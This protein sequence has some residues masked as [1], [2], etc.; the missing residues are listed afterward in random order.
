MVAIPKVQPRF[1]IAIWK[2]YPTMKS[3]L[4]VYMDPNISVSEICLFLF[5]C[6]DVCASVSLECK[7]T[8]F[9]TTY[10]FFQLGMEFVRVFGSLAGSLLFLKF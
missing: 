4:S 5:K 3:L 6:F 10:F 9:F 1:A 8:Y 2:K 7:D